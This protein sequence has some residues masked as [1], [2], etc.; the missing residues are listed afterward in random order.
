MHTFC[1]VHLPCYDKQRLIDKLIIFI[2]LF[3]LTLLSNVPLNTSTLFIEFCLSKMHLRSFSVAFKLM[4]CQNYKLVKCNIHFYARMRWVP[5]L[6][7]LYGQRWIQHWQSFAHSFTLLKYTKSMSLYFYVRLVQ[8]L[9][10]Y[11]K[12]N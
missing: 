3:V 6:F 4:E 2:F 7:V 10:F 1:H 12:L 11:M 5:I 8:I 9:R